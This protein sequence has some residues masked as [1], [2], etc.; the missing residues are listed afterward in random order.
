MI[1]AN[2]LNIYFAIQFGNSCS[3]GYHINV[4]KEKNV[5]AAKKVDKVIEI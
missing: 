4:A 3:S 5:M 2:E 1:M